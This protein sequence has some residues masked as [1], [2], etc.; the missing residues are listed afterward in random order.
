MTVAVFKLNIGFSSILKSP[1]FLFDTGAQQSVANAVENNWVRPRVWRKKR[2]SV[3]TFCSTRP[4]PGFILK[5]Q[6][7]VTF[8][9]PVVTFIFAVTFAVTLLCWLLA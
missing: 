8:E 1:G 7:V 2:W 6:S 9:K 4:G 3:H 5:H